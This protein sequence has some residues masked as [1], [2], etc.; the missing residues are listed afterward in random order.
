MSQLAKVL[1]RPIEHI[2]IAVN[3]IRHLDPAPGLRY[4]GAGA[5]QVEPDVYISKDGEDYVIS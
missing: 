5:R 2:Q 4:S 1:G 3:V